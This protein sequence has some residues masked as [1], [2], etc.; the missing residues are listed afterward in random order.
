MTRRA[1]RRITKTTRF[2]GDEAL[3]GA[4]HCRQTLLEGGQNGD[5]GRPS[6]RG[7]HAAEIELAPLAL[8]EQRSA[9]VAGHD[10]RIE[11]PYG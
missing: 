6:L 5:L 11:A 2:C 10:A 8:D 3:V 7:D 4:E 1:S 9:T